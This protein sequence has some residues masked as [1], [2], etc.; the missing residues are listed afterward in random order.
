MSS[1]TAYL[2]SLHAKFSAAEGEI[3]DILERCVT[4]NRDPSDDE[5][6]QIERA[7][8]D[9]ATL[10]KSIEDQTAR[11]ERS[12][13]VN[14][15]RGRFGGEVRQVVE[16]NET[17][18][19]MLDE[20]PTAGHY[21]YHLHRAIVKGDR[22]SRAILERVAAEQTT[23]DNA[24]I[25][26]APIVGSVVDIVKGRRRFINSV[27]GPQKAVANKFNRP[28]V[29]QHVDLGTQAA[30]LD[31]LTSQKMSIT[32]LPV[33]LNTIGGYVNLSKQDVR[34]SQPGILDIMYQ[35]FSK[36]YARRSNIKACAD[37]LTYLTQTE[38]LDWSD[39]IAAP[40]TKLDAWLVGAEADLNEDASPDTLW[41]SR[42][43][44]AVL[45]AV[46][47]AMGAKAYNVPMGSEVGDVEGLRLIVDPHFADKTLV[48]GDSEYVEVYEDLEGFLTVELPSVAGQQVGYAGYIDTL[49]TEVDAFSMAAV[50]A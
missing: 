1:M 40:Q 28:Y 9:R 2:D 33:A 38:A 41:V 43:V 29:A 50:V 17:A 42:D 13:K 6:K 20:V 34:W 8:A 32:E 44:A 18:Y 27:G 16:R 11:L 45:R 21:A 49:V 39:F 14:T 24:G 5:R 35:S 19:N 31:E 37:F 48:L 22:D 36:I 30:E 25:I 23:A 10:E 12:N 26:P 46:R 3:A 7:E 4:E 15:L 47:N